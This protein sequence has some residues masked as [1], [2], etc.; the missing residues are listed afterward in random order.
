M[1]NPVNYRPISLTSSLAELGEKLIAIRFKKFLKKNNTIIQQQS[2]LRKHR[3]TKDNL[4]HLTQKITESFKRRK[5][6][7]GI[8]FDIQKAFD[9]VWHKGL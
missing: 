3:Q 2:G 1:S 8:F 7:F 4:I 9:K 6:V 5:K